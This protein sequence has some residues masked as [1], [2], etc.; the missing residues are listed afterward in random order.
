MIA[1]AA[2]AAAVR[3]EEADMFQDSLSEGHIYWGRLMAILAT[4]VALVYLVPHL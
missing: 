1:L 2:T 4:A 3:S